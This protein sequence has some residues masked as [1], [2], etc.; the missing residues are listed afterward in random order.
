VKEAFREEGLDYTVRLLHAYIA[1]GVDGIHLYAMNQ[2]S[3][4]AELLRRSGLR[5]IPA[6]P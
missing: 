2:Y 5:N 4:V 1:E 6:E 3:N